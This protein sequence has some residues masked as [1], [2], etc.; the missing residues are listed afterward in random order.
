MVLLVDVSQVE[1]RF[2]QFKMVLSL[3]QYWFM[4]C[5][6]CIVGLKVILDIVLMSMQ[7]SCTI[8]A[9]RAIVS[10][11]VLGAPDRTR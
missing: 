4:I 1:A 9:E 7:Y 8:Y 3:T 6:E 5:T 11:I 10:E 2:G